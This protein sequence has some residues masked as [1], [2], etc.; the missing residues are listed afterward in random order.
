MHKTKKS[1]ITTPWLTK[2]EKY[3]GLGGKSNLLPYDLVQQYKTFILIK[4]Y[5]S[6]ENGQTY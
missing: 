2:W 5:N 1:T 6:F 3:D 4:Q